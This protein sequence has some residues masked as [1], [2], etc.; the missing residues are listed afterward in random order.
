MEKFNTGRILYNRLPIVHLPDWFLVGDWFG[1]AWLPIWPIVA[2]RASTSLLI[3]IGYQSGNNP[4]DDRF[5]TDYWLIDNDLILVHNL[6]YIFDWY[7]IEIRR[8]V[9]ARLVTIGE[10]GNKRNP[11][12]HQPGINRHVPD[13]YLI[14]RKLDGLVWWNSNA[15]FKC[16]LTCSTIFILKNTRL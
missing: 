15:Q 8:L 9:D 6:A 13:W 3:S 7:P 12:S 2:D 16:N 14:D 10:I 1:S 4:I 11:I 5:M